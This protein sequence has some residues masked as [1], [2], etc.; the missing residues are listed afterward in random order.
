MTVWGKRI[1]FGIWAS[2]GAC[3]VVSFL[4]FL[5]I[6][7]GFIGYMPP[8][9]QL[10]N[11]IDKY[12]SQIISSDG[13]WLGSFSYGK[14]N[15]I[16]VTYNELSPDLVKALIATEDIRYTSHSGIDI[17]GLLRAIIKTGLLRQKSGGGGSTITQQLAKQLYSPGV[18]TF[19]ERIFQKPIEWVIA[20]QLERYY[21]K[22]E[23]VNLYLN[24]FDFLYNAVGIKSAARVYFGATPAELKTEEA[25]TLIGMCKNPSL[26][27]PNRYNERTRERRNMVLSQM[28][29]A[30]YL[31]AAACDSLSRLPLELR[32]SRMDHIDGSAPYFREY[33]R[34][35]LTA[36]KP[37]RSNYFAWQDQKFADDST[38][39]ETNPLYGWCNKNRKPNGDPYDIYTDGLK[40][41]ST[42]D[43]HMQKYAEEAVAEHVGGALQP[44]F[45]RRKAGQKNA[46][47]SRDLTEDEISSILD[48]AL[49]LSD[50][51]RELK[52]TGMSEADIRKSFYQPVD[53]RVFS[54]GGTIDTTMTPM[55]SIRYY[56]SFLRSA[57]MAMDPHTGQVKAYVGGIDFNSFKYD[58]ATD[59]RRQIGSAMKPFVYSL[60][61]ING[62]NPTDKVL[63]VQP[64][65]YDEN[66]NP[67]EP[68]NAGTTRVGEE[69]TV[70]WGLQQS[71]NWV[72]AILMKQL[73]PYTMVRFL[74]SFG[75]RGQIDPVV[76]MCLG[77][78]DISVSEMVSAYSVFPSKGIR[79][80][81]LFVTRIENSNGNEIA[82]FTPKMNEVL[83]ENTTY[84]TLSMLRSVLDG[85]TASRVRYRYGI[86]APMGGKTGTTQNQSD[87][88]FMGFTPRLVAGCWVGGEDRSI[89]FDGLN[90]GQGAAMALPIFALFM[91]KV[92]ADKTLGY[93]E[94]EDFDKS[95]NLSYTIDITDNNRTN[96]NPLELDDFFE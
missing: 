52:K 39:W 11:P 36:K 37:V 55:D 48:R 73:S 35:V 74:H 19:V 8:V 14:D 82:T 1:I 43:S 89:R 32:F 25:A 7:K 18:S 9:E 4:L 16:N 15:R 79:M 54:W 12:A 24:K 80:E 47:F 94:T 72:T 92:Y 45:T 29:K 38:A 41:Y 85:G 51:Y 33:L 5:A 90:E 84:K 23:I 21:T 34:L 10:E 42:V 86:R 63:H 53:M 64:L 95:G 22:E 59:G 56:K 75:F 58:M 70:A 6:S 65:L 88:W 27:N 87:G 66:G 44:D 61:M 49:V 40:I 30:G 96:T 50:R 28:K 67:W 13:Q 69:V 93:S 78:P 31:T 76:S 83:D 20:V 3:I 57:F 17:R 62:V 81:P 46:P 91:Q 26:Y 2:L 71:S 60:A 68:R 77:T